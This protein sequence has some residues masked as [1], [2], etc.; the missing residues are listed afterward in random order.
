MYAG[1]KYRLNIDAVGSLRI[2][3]QVDATRFACK[4]FWTVIV[5]AVLLTGA[6]ILQAQQAEKPPASDEK[7]KVTGPLSILKGVTQ[8]QEEAITAPLV[9]VGPPPSEKAIPLTQVA[10]SAEELDRQLAEISKQLSMAPDLANEERETRT[11]T[12]EVSQRAVAVDDLLKGKLNAA[13]LED[14]EVYWRNLSVQSL[15]RRKALSARAVILEGQIRI[16][17]EQNTKWQ[18]TWDQIQD[19]AGIEEV[20]ARVRQE[21]NAI[22][23][24]Q[25]LAQKQL[26]LVLTLQNLASQSGRQIA[27][28]IEKINVAEDQFRGRLLERDSYPLWSAGAYRESSQEIGYSL[29]RSASKDY[30]TTAEFLEA[31]AW[32]IVLAIFLF[33]LALMLSFRLKKYVESGN[34]PGVP[35]GAVE[36]FRRPY[37]VA[38]VLALA[39]TI[40]E[41][42]SA[43][44][45]IGAALYLLW[46]LAT[47]RLLPSLIKPSLKPLLYTLVVSNLLSGIRVWIPY[48]AP[49]RRLFLALAMLVGVLVVGWLTRIYRLQNLENVSRRHAL[50]VLAIRFGLLLLTIGLFANI[51]GYV[52]L[53]HF[54]GAGVLLSA[55]SATSLYC[56]VRVLS[57]VLV[58]TLRSPLGGI[59]SEVQRWQA[60][61]WGQ[62]I[63]ILAAIFLW[64]RVQVFLFAMND[65]MSSFTSGLLEYSISLGKMEFTV[66][67]LISVLLILGAGYAVAK[68]G[69][70]LLRYLLTSRLTLQRGL[71]YAIS[72]VAYYVLMLLVLFAAVSQAGVEL[73]KFT[74]ITGALGVGVG[75]G[76]QNIVNNFASG[77]ILLFERPI[78]V[79]D[80]VEVN[81]L[82]GTV[83]R[84]G[85]RSSTI[86]TFQG[87]EVI[88]PNSNLLSNQVINWT[89]SSPWR[90][91]D[92][93]VGVAYGNDP[94][95][96]IKL[97]VSVADKNTGVMHEPA[98]NAFFLG[99]GD[100]SLNF[101]LRFWSARQDTW[102]QLKSDVAI[103]VAEALQANGIEVPFPQRDLHVRSADPLLKEVLATTE[104][105]SQVLPAG[106]MKNLT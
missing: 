100:S 10:D 91:V 80:T 26:K 85:G 63:F 72:K 71:P 19:P 103:A 101:E 18:A 48:S 41:A 8:P 65:N 58:T 45:S 78:R 20:A 98:P 35:P 39:S 84:I 14:E 42:S 69:T 6:G 23:N 12:E 5:F 99:F 7:V 79:E 55:M 17:G 70:L 61:T 50:L 74:V 59:L 9:P 89:L 38:L 25:A 15:A 51:A 44:L 75:F 40:G 21:L 16:L 73:N 92:I 24:L 93:P 3:R 56:F 53:S 31:K 104:K 68:A 94:K 4:A 49:I 29:R 96:I 13:E 66:G 95:E 36:I 86:Q 87:A 90:R 32:K 52:L 102:F 28:A 47:I 1:F 83:K 105:A 22:Q 37:S 81:G 64:L 62:R 2:S 67:N 76:L 43:P 88:V 82:V 97:L 57:I 54:L 11:Q 27:D 77:L 33:A 34:Q 106:R 46:L 30:T 60:E